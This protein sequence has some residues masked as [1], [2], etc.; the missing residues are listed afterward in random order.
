MSS[1]PDPDAD[2]DADA[3][4]VPAT[5]R[6]LPSHG[7][8]AAWRLQEE[9]GLASLPRLCLSPVQYYEAH[10]FG[11]P[12][13]FP[14]GHRRHDQ[15][16][17]A[18]LDLPGDLRDDIEAWIDEWKENF[19]HLGDRPVDQPVWREGFDELA[20]LDR[21]HELADR[22]EVSL[23]GTAVFCTAERY[24][25]CELAAD[26]LDYVHPLRG[27]YVRTEGWRAPGNGPDPDRTPTI[28]L[29]PEYG[30][31]WGL[32]AGR[33]PYYQPP[34]LRDGFMDFATP[35]SLGLTADLE[36]RIL[37]WNDDWRRGFADY[38]SSVDDSGA[39][40]GLL[41][42]GYGVPVWT[43]GVDPV[44]WYREGLAIARRL[45]EEL[46]GVEVELV[47]IRNV[48]SARL[49]MQDHTSHLRG[50]DPATYSDVFLSERRRVGS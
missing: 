30:V 24:V 34:R 37:R 48:C 44:D 14:P 33:L 15:G 9:P 45:A 28:R 8:R 12:S 23:T 42:Y 49:V 43:D 38:G 50:Q 25:V 1:S 4:S 40:L 2:A 29:M 7:S 31:T 13:A 5:P 27:D 17:A 6:V 18:D 39:A 46:P 11:S 41:G 10:L 22:L 47:A 35:R 3:D 26:Q 21:G 36:S 16:V 20:W 32:W 19:V